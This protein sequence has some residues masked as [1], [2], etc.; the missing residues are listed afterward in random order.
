[1]EKAGVKGF[2]MDLRDNPGG[3]LDQAVKVSEKFLPRGQL[4]VSTEARQIA[5]EIEA[6]ILKRT[7]PSGVCPIS[8]V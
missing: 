1:M 6:H 2:I 8:S 3:L 5:D 7:C 4:V